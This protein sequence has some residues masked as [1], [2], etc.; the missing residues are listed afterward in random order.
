MTT[1]Y[2]KAVAPSISLQTADIVV[3]TANKYFPQFQLT[4]KERVSAFVAQLA[5]ESLQFTKTSENLNYSAEGL[6][7]TFP[8]YFD[9]AT[10]T[11]YA[12]KPQAIANR[13]YANRMGNGSEASGDGWKFRGRGFIQLTG[14]ANYQVMSKAMFGNET[15][16]LKNP[17]ILER[18]DYALLSALIYW[19]LKGLNQYADRNDFVNITKAINGKLNGYDD[20]VNFWQK[21]KTY[22]SLS[23]APKVNNWWEQFLKMFGL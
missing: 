8:N 10:A 12:R 1:N 23:V 20:R 3:S 9:R 19:K 11:R 7:G 6:L 22:F 16:L 21:A 2:I 13:A 15:T 18:P 17:E 14:K 5:H 4:T